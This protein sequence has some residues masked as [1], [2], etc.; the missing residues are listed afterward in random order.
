MDLMPQ[1][2]TRYVKSGDAY[3]AYQVVGGGPIDLLF[4]SG[5]ALSIDV[6]W[7]REEPA[8]FFSNL[9]SFSR[10]LMFDRRGIGLSDPV[11]QASPPTIELWMDDALAVLDAAGSTRAA[12]MGTD[13]VGGHV[14][15]LLG[16]THP[17]RISHVVVCNSAANATRV[18]GQ[19]PT[20]TRLTNGDW[21]STSAAARAAPSKAND[22]AFMEWL[23][24]ARRRSVS[25]GVSGLMGAAAAAG[26][27]RGILSSIR[28]PT[29]VMHR[30]D[31]RTISPDRGRKIAEGIPG[32]RFVE[33]EGADQ[34]LFVGDSDAIVSEVQEFVTGVRPIAVADRVLA[35]ILFSDIVSSTQAVADAG[36]RRWTEK[37]EAH[38]AAIRRQLERFGGVHVGTTGDGFVATFDG[39]ARAIQ[40]A[41]AVHD[42]LHGLGLQVR[43]GI[44][45]G[46]IER[47]RD[48]VAGIAV[49]IAQRI[50]GL[51]DAGRTL[52]SR[53]VTDLVAGSGISFDDLGT[54][55]LKGVPD[56]W[57]VYAVVR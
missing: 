37:L 47:R 44:H 29:L 7:E 11:S 3:I 13:V 6:C 54:Q 1:P 45:T 23:S 41:G 14:A 35:T 38:D 8:R 5:I 24:R 51:A 20:T 15:L 49:H 56:E 25:P 4:A 52:V 57:H 26:D 39:P 36:D 53:T 46:E 19:G 17:D 43:I 9:A 48:D 16:A 18:P 12:V 55:R 22:D 27:V 33:L 30:M 40:C 32:A 10:L 21:L 42:A 31:N 2:E 34:W 50:S 28:L